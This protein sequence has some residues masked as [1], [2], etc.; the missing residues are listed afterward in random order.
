MIKLSVLLAFLFLVFSGKLIGQTVVK[1]VVKDDSNQT[2][3]Y[4]AVYLSKTTIGTMTNKEGFFT[5]TV[6]QE[7]VYEL[8]SSC[9]GYT[10]KSLMINAEGK[11]LT[12]N[13]EL[14]ENQIQL[15][16]VTVKSK[17][18]N[19]E[20]NYTTFTKLF[21]GE[22]INSLNCKILNPEDLYLYR[23]P[24]TNVLKGQSLK[25]LRIENKSLGY[26]ILYDLTDFSYD[27]KN[28]LLKF[29]GSPYFQPLK[30]GTK[31]DKK[32]ARNRLSAY[33]GSR[34]HLLRSIFADS[35]KQSKFQ[36]FQAEL[37]PSRK[38]TMKVIPISE[39][40]IRFSRS[41]KQMRIFSTKPVLINYLDTH[42]ELYNGLFGFQPQR[43]KSSLEFSDTVTVYQN[44]F[45]LNPY[46]I[47]WSGKMAAE[48]IADLIPYDFLS[49]SATKFKADTV[50]TTPS[51]DNFITSGQNTTCG[52][53]LFVQL[54]RNKYR[55][56]DTI[57]FQTYVRDRFSSVFR[58]NSVYMYAL[59][60]NGS[61]VLSDSARFKIEN[62]TAS[63][64]LTIPVKAEPGIYHFVAF[65]S[66]M[67][68]A[69]PVEAFQ[70]D[71][72]VKEPGINIG[73]N[74]EA[75]HA[76]GPVPR[77]DL[78]FLPEGGSFIH[79]AE[80]R[81]GFNATNENGDPI[82]IEGLLKNSLGSILDTIRSGP[83]G[84]GS[85]SCKAISGL[86][87]ELTK[88]PE[89]QKRWP[90]P[91]PI[92]SGYSLGV[93]PAG[94]R[95]VVVDIQSS[96]Y[97]GEK[98]IVAGTLNMVRFFFQEVNLTKRQQIIVDTGSLPSGVANIT[99]FDPSMK[100]VAERLTYL[101]SDKHLLFNIQSEKSISHPGE[102]T[103]LA[104]SVID[105]VGKPSEG[106]FSIAVTDSLRGMDYRLFLPGIE[107]TFNYHPVFPGNL[108]PKV[109]AYGLENLSDSERDLL[110]MVY[111]WS[112]I[113]WDFKKL[114][115]DTIQPVNYDLL[116]LKVLY[117]GKRTREKSLDLV[118]LEGASSRH[119][120]TDGLGEISLPLDSLSEITRSVIMMPDVKSKNKAAGAML[121]IPYNEQY[122]KSNKLHLQQPLLPI[123]EHIIT[124]SEQPV[125][126]EEKTIEIAEVTIIGHQTEKI[127][128]DEYERIYQ[129]DN[130]KSLDYEPL[131]S[132][133]TLETAIRKLVYP[134][135]ITNSNIYLRS[136]ISFMH[137]PLP[138]LI[139][140]DGMPL[141]DGGWPR[142]NTIS[143][144]E[145]TSLTI[146][147]SRMGYVR[148]GEAAQGGVIF[149][150]TRS[151]DPNLTRVRTKWNLQNS[152]DK[153][154]RPINLYRPF[155][156]FY[157]P[158]KVEL[159]SNPL[160]QGRPTIFWQS[161]VY[162]W[163]K[164]PVKI[165]F[166]NLKHKGPVVITVNGVSVDN[167]VGSGRG[168]YLVE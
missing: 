69:N 149:V 132:S 57:F 14:S 128:K 65:T 102:E 44:G 34:L 75:A 90:L 135:S 36:L 157:N 46:S 33:Y 146:L 130:V 156:E 72:S 124:A 2:I 100:P 54:D 117:E 80:Q 104:I 66:Q 58:T 18:K 70:L 111:G 103:E 121:S 107:Y 108:P 8:I 9:L 158:S 101:N 85:F 154:L 51:I 32:W 119:L 59:L 133:S 43:Y 150:N 27:D 52:D 148:Y 28:E 49:Y 143:P 40:N 3:P 91:E 147:D 87:V 56:G 109:L 153:M 123:Q 64:W 63:G 134:Y 77:M 110:L 99:L 141:Y 71:L 62:S 165:K 7:G 164:D 94:N 97:T 24:N 131:W 142:V 50:V 129:A 68:N 126:M 139:V 82:P 112:K 13:I 67:Q 25:S 89:G 152:N 31:E 144:S 136:T 159:E 45:F 125:A 42:A 127:Y 22:T 17:D 47:T 163:G 137:G 96:M 23:I 168:R 116:K 74:L 83:F 120:V 41:M 81:V 88:G 61:K 98:V 162:F 1:G 166:P 145:V 19:R 60:F 140:L 76:A 93:A 79:G 73:K 84:P 37:D 118:S 106:F 6:R 15:D 151:S 86:F 160:L 122:F 12:V 26:L 11:T 113:N 78:R 4:A 114:K 138:A 48:R 115:P 167:L 30:G 53:Q 29:T 5:L 105:G 155:V 92:I 10:T 161:E 21:L 35:L 16:E 55:P 20:K 95:S 38:D 39:K